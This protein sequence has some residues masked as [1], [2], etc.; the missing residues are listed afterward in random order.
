[1]AFIEQDT[2]AYPSSD[3]GILIE[4]EIDSGGFKEDPKDIGESVVV[5]GYRGALFPR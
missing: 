3:G 5:L 1:L 4:A 2:T